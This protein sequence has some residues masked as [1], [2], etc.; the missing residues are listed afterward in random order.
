V[1]GLIRASG[2]MALALLASPAFAKDEAPCPAGMVCA[3]DPQTVASAMQ[4]AGYA[5]K[6][7]TDN[8]GD[9]SVTSAAA[10]YNFDVLFYGCEEH[11][12]CDSLQFR[13]TFIPYANHGPEMANKWNEKKRFVQASVRPDKKMDFSYDVTTLGGLTKANFADAVDWWAV[14]LGEVFKFFNENPPGEKIETAK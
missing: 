4:A 9:P 14:S 8:Q 5:A 11:K 6:I 13:L 12:Q 2:I 1:R 10:G 7:E 3:S